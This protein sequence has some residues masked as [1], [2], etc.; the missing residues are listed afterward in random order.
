VDVFPIV[1]PLQLPPGIAGPEPVDADVR[2]FAVRD[3]DRVILVDTGMQ[4]DGAE[5]D[6]AFAE[7]GL[8]WADVS[9]VVLTH[10]HPDHIGALDHVIAQATKAKVWSGDSLPRAELLR[11]GDQV[12]P[13]RVIRTPGHAPGHVCLVDNDTGDVFV[14]DCVG[15]FGGGLQRAPAVFTADPAEADRSL[16]R[17]AGIG[18]RRMYFSHGAEIDDPWAS[19]AALVGQ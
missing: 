16:A 7:A 15:T 10:H 6:A 19:L 3:A 18:G 14:G 17:L 2:A 5:L 8:S 9:D 13:L 11:D 12:G 1:M 4:A